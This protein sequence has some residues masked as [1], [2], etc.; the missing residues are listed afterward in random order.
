MAAYLSELQSDTP[1][2]FTG[3]QSSYS[4]I[5]TAVSHHVSL[6]SRNCVTAI[7]SLGYW[8]M[9]NRFS[10]FFAIINYLLLATITMH[11]RPIYN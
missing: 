2:H 1:F 3:S 7:E 8:S 10:H 11:S 5:V 6:I 9:L 4:V